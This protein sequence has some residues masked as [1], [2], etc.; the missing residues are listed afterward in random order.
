MATYYLAHN[1][2]GTPAAIPT[3][4]VPQ[5]GDGTATGVAT[6]SSIASLLINAVAVAGSGA[7]AFAIAAAEVLKH[8]F[9]R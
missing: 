8:F 7:A 1:A 2:Y 3:W 9:S 6:A 4:G 5:E